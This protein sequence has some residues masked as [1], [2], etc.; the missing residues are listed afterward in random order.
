MLNLV[1]G[2]AGYVGSHLVNTLVDAGERTIILD[3]LST[4]HVRNLE[5]ALSSGRAT[6]AYADVAVP[7]FRLEEIVRDVTRSRIDRIYHLA[8]PGS[9]PARISDPWGTL[10]ADGL[11]TM[12][13]VELALERGARL[14]FASQ[15]HAGVVDPLGLTGSCDEGKRFGEALLAAAARKHGLDARVVRLYNC[16]GPGMAEGDGRLIPALMGA[17]LDG[18]P[19]PIHG[20]GMQTRCLTYVNDAAELMRLAM[21]SSAIGLSPVDAGSADERTVDE[22]ARV[23][24][25][26]AGVEYAPVF[27]PET[28]PDPVRRRPD[29]MLAKQIGWS[30][31]TALSV[32]IHATYRWFREAR[33]VYA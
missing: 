9:W 33:L 5:Y 3:N 15:D 12:S 11:A 6:F 27:L 23:I 20:T 14:L 22:I 2:G 4:G 17:A 32:G 10:A 29:L 13:L 21:E 18:K 8:S 31:S 28:E 26:T 24:A 16:Y 25:A 19:L 1:T 7:Y 30:A